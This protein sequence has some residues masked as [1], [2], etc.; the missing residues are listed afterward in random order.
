MFL[1][2]RIGEALAGNLVSPAR[3]LLVYSPFVVFSAWGVWQWMRDG[4][5]RRLGWFTAAACVGQYLLI[6]SYEDWFGGECYGPRYLSDLSPLYALA[7]LPA[8]GLGRRGKAAAG[9]LLA[10]SLFMHA[11]GALCWPCVEWNAKPTRVRENQWRLWDWK[12][13]AF[14]RNLRGG[15]TAA[16]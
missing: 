9:A 13:P 16:E 3:G 14:L 15:S 10:V 1:H 5:L 2:P 7:L 11:Q 4:R 8:L 12:D 6:C